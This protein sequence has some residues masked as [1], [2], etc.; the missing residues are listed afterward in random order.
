MSNKSINQLPEAGNSLPGDVYILVRGGVN[1]KIQRSNMPPAI[2]TAQVTIPSADVLTLNTTPV[3][4]VPAA[5]AGYVVIPVGGII[6]FANGSANYAVN[7]TL[8]AGSTTTISNTVYSIVGSIADR[9]IPNAI[10]AAAT[11]ILSPTVDG[12]S[13]SVKVITGN[14]TTGD[15]DLT[16][17]IYYYLQSV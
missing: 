8:V 6:E 14:P 12:D 15:S 1:Y 11:S 7:T 3:L 17:T 16:I 13:V 9:T 5:P 10:A 2:L 4:V